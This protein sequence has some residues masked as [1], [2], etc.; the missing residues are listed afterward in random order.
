MGALHSLLDEFGDGAAFVGAYISEAHASDVW[1]IRSSR[2]ADRVVDMRA[3]RCA[4]DRAAAAAAF[5]ADYGLRFPLLCADMDGAF[6]AAYSPWPL[7]FFG[8]CVLTGRLLFVGQPRD[9]APDLPALR[10]FLAGLAGL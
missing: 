2:F 5:A 6:E 7:R 4:A 3:P 10:A 1:P 9:A 8:V